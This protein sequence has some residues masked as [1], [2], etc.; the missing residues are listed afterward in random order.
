MVMLRR[1]VVLRCEKERRLPL[2]PARICMAF[3]QFA[4]VGNKEAKFC[5]TILAERVLIIHCSNRVNFPK[6]SSQCF[7]SRDVGYPPKRSLQFRHPVRDSS[8]TPAPPA[9]VSISRLS[10]GP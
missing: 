3:E 8:V 6:A 7:E 10:W 4:Q 2:T 1:L 5:L 9:Q